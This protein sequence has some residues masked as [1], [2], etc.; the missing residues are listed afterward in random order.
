[1]ITSALSNAAA[2]AA[3]DGGLVG[4]RGWGSRGGMANIFIMA[5]MQCAHVNE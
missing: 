1:M 3:G 2:A 5:G 4:G